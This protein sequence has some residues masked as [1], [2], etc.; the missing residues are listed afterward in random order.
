MT[1]GLF[2][3]RPDIDTSVTQITNR[4][5]DVGYTLD[6]TNRE[7]E[8]T[9][10]WTFFSRPSN[11]FNAQLVETRRSDGLVFLSVLAAVDGP[12]EG[13]PCD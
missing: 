7:G 3:N 13:S 9:Q 2:N 5:L 11:T 8:G 1:Y 10:K 6:C 12:F 4:L